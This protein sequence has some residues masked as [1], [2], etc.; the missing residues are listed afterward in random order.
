[1]V[2][3]DASILAQRPQKYLPLSA[4]PKSPDHSPRFRPACAGA[5]AQARVLLIDTPLDHPPRSHMYLYECGLL[6]KCLRQTQGIETVISEGWPND[7]AVIEGVTR[8]ALYSN[9]GQHRLRTG[10][11]SRRAEAVR[12]RRR[13]SQFIG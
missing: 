8:V 10:E 9:P 3:F 12:C 6:E 5:G 1:M 11:S 2:S 4:A 7:S 13:V